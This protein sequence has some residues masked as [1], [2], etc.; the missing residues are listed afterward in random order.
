M[1]VPLQE[2]AHTL[3]R[4]WGLYLSEP[5]QRGLAAGIF[6]GTI[7]AFA[8]LAWLTSTAYRRSRH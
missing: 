7:A 8:G 6:A 2:T 5:Q 3:N 1:R 4:R